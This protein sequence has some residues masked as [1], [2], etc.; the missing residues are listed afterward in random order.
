M[1]SYRAHRAEQHVRLLLLRQARHDGPD[2]AGHD[3]DRH[4]A[5][6]K[7]Q[8][9]RDGDRGEQ[10]GRRRIGQRLQLPSHAVTHDATH[11][12]TLCTHTRRVHARYNV[13][14]LYDAHARARRVGCVHG[15]W[16]LQLREQKQCDDVVEH[17]GGDD[18][19]AGGR[20]EHLGLLE[21]VERDT[22]RC[23]R[24]RAAHGECRLGEGVRCA[25]VRAEVVAVMADLH[26]SLTH[27]VTQL[28]VAVVV[29][30]CLLA[31][32]LTY[33]LSYLPL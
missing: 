31:Y 3:E 27:I 7:H 32:L 12:T 22:H 33:S 19:L 4:P 21:D 23:G 26:Y 20:V 24:Q 9:E 18:E 28:V 15:A 10:R 29:L 5:E 14:L 1:T 30:T 25:R 6:E 17:G 2:E 8:A 13:R 16:R 11:D